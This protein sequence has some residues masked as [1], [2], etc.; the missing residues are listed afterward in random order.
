[1]QAKQGRIFIGRLPFRADLLEALHALCR[2]HDIRLGVF[3]VIGA[4]KEAKLGYYIQDEKRYVECVHL[5]KKLEITC[6]TGNISLKDDN[7]FIHAHVTLADHE[8]NCYGGHLMAG[9]RIFAAEYCIT[10]LTGGILERTE[11]PRTGLSLW[12]E[13]EQS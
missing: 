6:C 2:E 13:E 3:S 4:V 5:E 10:E 9:S 1:M 7:I 8:G 11:D 12:Y